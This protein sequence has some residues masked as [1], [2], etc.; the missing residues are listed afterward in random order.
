MF[1]SVRSNSDGSGE[2]SYER[3]IL[4][5]R[6]L[7]RLDDPKAATI[8]PCAFAEGNGEAKACSAALVLATCLEQFERE[9]ERG[10][11]DTGRY[12][13]NY[14]V[15]GQGPPLIV[16]PGL[17][18]F[19]D[20]FVLPLARLHDKFR[21]ITYDLPAGGFDGAKL[22]GHRHG[23]LVDDLF[24]LCDYLHLESAVLLGTSFGS[25]IA[26]SALAR[27][28]KRFPTAILQGGFAHR[29]LAW[30]EV[31]LARFARYWP[32]NLVHLPGRRFIADHAHRA[33][34][35]DCEPARW[36]HF[37]SHQG[38][39]RNAAIAHRALLLHGIDLRPILPTIRQPILLVRGDRDRLVSRHCAEELRRGLP[40]VLDGE[41]E[42][43]G[44]LPQ[45]TH[46]EVFAELIEQFLATSHGHLGPCP[47]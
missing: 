24:A 2:P 6:S 22:A 10:V 31:L 47:S 11:C 41:I 45:F 27:D 18:D 35:A 17:C 26:L 13:M 5:A 38:A 14:R 19:A 16:V 34:F 21:C 15:W 25:T 3:S 20:S 4:A 30:A 1:V 29:P 33:E 23:D 32:G 8:S 43:C 7:P 39:A 12:R 40:N 44:H 37:L 36:P 9:A 28:A 42:G 46:P